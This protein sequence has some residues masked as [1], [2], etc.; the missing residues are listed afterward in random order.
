[1]SAF[2]GA[3][4]ILPGKVVEAYR[5]A[6]ELKGPRADEWTASLLRLGVSCGEWFLQRLH[7]M[8][9]LIVWFEAQDPE[10]ALLNLASSDDAFDVWFRRAVLEFTGE[11]LN[12]FAARPLPQ[13]VLDYSV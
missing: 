10:A 8:D 4:P 12:D 11:D 3:F 7:G 5:L 1:V 6:G 2:C 9:L 13:K